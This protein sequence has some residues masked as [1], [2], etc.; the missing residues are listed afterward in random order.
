VEEGAG[1]KENQPQ[2]EQRQH[3]RRKVRSGM[4][5][6]TAWWAHNLSSKRLLEN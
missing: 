4:L 3:D 1:D 5:S 6:K 2:R